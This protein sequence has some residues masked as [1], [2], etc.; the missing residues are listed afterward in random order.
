MEFQTINAQ[1]GSIRSIG[2]NSNCTRVAVCDMLY[3][4]LIKIYD[5]MTSELIGVIEHPGH[6][7]LLTYSPDNSELA[8]WSN[9][10]IYFWKTYPDIMKR[11][12]YRNDVAILNFSYSSDGNTIGYCSKNYF[13]LI[14]VKTAQRTN[15]AWN[16][17]RDNVK[18]IAFSLDDTKCATSDADGIIM[19]WN[20]IDCMKI[21]EFVS[22]CGGIKSFAFNY[23][24][25]I[26]VAGN[27]K[28][29]MLVWNVSNENMIKLLVNYNNP[30]V[31]YNNPLIEHDNTVL[32]IVFSSNDT[33]ITCD[34]N[35]MICSWN[36]ST[37]HLLGKIINNRRIT[38]AK[39]NLHKNMIVAG[40]NYGTVYLQN[41]IFSGSHTK[42]ALHDFDQQNIVDQSIIADIV[43]QT[44]TNSVT[45]SIVVNQPIIAD[46]LDQTIIAD[47]LDQ[48]IT[49]ALD[50]VNV[51]QCPYLELDDL[52]LSKL[53]N[54]I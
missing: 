50:Q 53:D 44:P 49:N 29:K 48:T 11:C 24:G 12:T 25:D 30:M 31:N 9:T 22:Y 28:G 19:I 13:G 40:N 36:V 34:A 20:V 51:I 35:M 1:I 3:S 6:V 33:F 10:Q 17:H 5:T 39:I 43:D 18:S 42:G 32:L 15:I 16:S 38:T 23:N 54:L 52:D 8:Y 27:Y 41:I 46:T 14:D 37:G 26:T 47:V 4:G 7:D 45:Q 21:T 2:L